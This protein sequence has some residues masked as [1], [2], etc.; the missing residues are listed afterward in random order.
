MEK[1]LKRI[2]I[3]IYIIVVFLNCMTTELPPSHKCC[4]VLPGAVAVVIF[5]LFY[6][7]MLAFTL[8]F[9]LYVA[10]VLVR[11][12]FSVVWLRAAPI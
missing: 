6:F 12:T 8:L 7:D 4:F 1:G 5:I 2:F 11:R 9:F 3:Y 10:S